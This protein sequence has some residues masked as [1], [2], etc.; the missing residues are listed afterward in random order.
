MS[1]LEAEGLAAT[2]LVVVGVTAVTWA[3]G[4]FGSAGMCSSWF[5]SGWFGSIGF[6]GFWLGCITG[7]CG[8]S[9]TGGFSRVGIVNLT[10]H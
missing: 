1:S 5:G 10:L 2:Y 3:G 7:F 8:L 9:G 6:G 4:G